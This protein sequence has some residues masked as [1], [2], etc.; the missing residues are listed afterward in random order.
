VDPTPLV[1]GDSCKIDVWVTPTTDLPQTGSLTVTDDAPDNP[2]TVGL[3]VNGGRPQPP[4]AAPTNRAPARKA[5]TTR[6]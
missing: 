3:A 1:V 6:R 5:G 4:A 2:Q